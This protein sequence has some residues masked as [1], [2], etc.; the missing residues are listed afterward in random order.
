M[1]VSE[2]RYSEAKPIQ[3]LMLR[4]AKNYRATFWCCFLQIHLSF[5][6]RGTTHKSVS[7]FG[8]LPQ[9]ILDVFL[10]SI[11]ATLSEVKDVELRYVPVLLALCVV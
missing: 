9:D 6:P 10:N 5:S 11:G 3:W 7:D 2:R 1:R 4:Q 8:S